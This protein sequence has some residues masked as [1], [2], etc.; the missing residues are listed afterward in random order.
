MWPGFF[1]SIKSGLTVAAATSFGFGIQ[2]GIQAG[3]QDAGSIGRKTP[4]A[5]GGFLF[6]Y[7]AGAYNAREHLTGIFASDMYIP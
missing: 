4:P 3:I 2:A 6:G 1:Q 7:S 5:V